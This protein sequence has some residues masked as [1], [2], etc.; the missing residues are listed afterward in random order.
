MMVKGYEVSTR[1]ERERLRWEDRGACWEDDDRGTE[2]SAG[3]ASVLATSQVH[4]YN[5][6]SDLGRRTCLFS[7]RPLSLIYVLINKVAVFSS[8]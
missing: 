4:P 1:T 2:T 8:V 7:P 6:D 3:S 5:L